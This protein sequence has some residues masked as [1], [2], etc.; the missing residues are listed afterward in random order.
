MLASVTIRNVVLIDSLT[1]EF[2]PGL[3]ALTGETGAGKSILL[4]ALGLATGARADRGLIR[5]GAEEASVTAEFSLTTGHPAF[6]LLAEAGIAQ[7][8][9]A[10]IL[11]RHLARDGRGRAFVNDQPVSVAFLQALGEALLEIHGQH[12][13]RGLI[14]PAGHRALLDEFGGLTGEVRAVAGAHAAWRAATEALDKRRTQLHQARAEADYLAHALGELS[15]LAP[16]EGE[17]AALA[18][19][20]ALMMNAGRIA[21]DLQEAA[22]ALTGDGGMEGRLSAALR[23]LE[24]AAG[25]AG[26]RLDAALAALERAQLEAGEARQAVEAALDGL[27]FEP[28]RL[29]EFE[30]RLFALRAQARKHNVPADDLPRLRADIAG[31]LD[32]LQKGEEGLAELEAGAEAARRAFEA[33]ARTLS[34]KRAVAAARLDRDVARELKPLKLEKA[35]FRTAI[36]ALPAERWGPEGMDRVRFE[37]ATNPGAPFGDLKQIASGG[38]LARFILALKVALAGQGS[39]GTLIFDEV[40]RGVGGAVADAVGERLARLASSGAQ[41]LVV[42]HSP[43]VAARAAHHWRIAKSEKKGRMVTS[44]AALDAA[45]RLEEVARM[46]AA[47][48]VTDEARAAA[49]RLL[50]NDSKPAGRAAE[51]QRA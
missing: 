18:S 5:H 34:E 17:E 24:R 31:K 16:Q 12:D 20:R 43:Q 42:T 22:D 27:E 10:L 28:R 39:A 50:Q 29:E 4:D 48:E 13:D 14:N 47:A 7:A 32:A 49:A 45:E 44:V 2:R 15:A 46:L 21:A 23:R 33:A 19:E 30:E 26:G 41:V 3:C 25:H 8:E 9:P 1:L 35:A 11:R 36:D 51:K 37:V 40:D 38:E 6:L